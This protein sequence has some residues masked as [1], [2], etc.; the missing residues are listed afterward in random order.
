MSQEAKS[1]ATKTVASLNFDSPSS[2][3][4]A[5]GKVVVDLYTELHARDRT[6]LDL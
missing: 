3:K 5:V 6:I 4:D 1:F 2:A